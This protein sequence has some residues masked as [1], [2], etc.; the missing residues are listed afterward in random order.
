[1]KLMTFVLSM[2]ISLSV[3]A[4]NKDIL[5]TV[6]GETITKSEFLKAYRQRKLFVGQQVVTKQGVLDDLIARRV[7][8]QKARAAK[9]ETDPIVLEKIEDIIY[10][11]QVSKDLEGELA[12]IKVS[13]LD[14]KNYYKVNPEYRTAQILIRVKAVPDKGEIENAYKVA[15]EIYQ[16]VKNNPDAFGQ[17]ANKFSQTTNRVNGGDMGYQPAVRYAPEYYAAINGK[18]V[19]FISPPV[20]SQFG[21]H[22]IKVLGVKEFKD[23]NLGIYKKIVYDT[24]RDQIIN[25]YKKEQLRNAKV[26]VNKE[27]LKIVN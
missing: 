19:N 10:N 26:I 18:K 3:F 4:N 1:M 7:G 14:A 20:K 5:A 16:K 21:F 25:Q 22:V 12:K 13:D 15:S 17:F 27:N 6:N 24:K 9:L 11:A 8:I 23:V 2:T